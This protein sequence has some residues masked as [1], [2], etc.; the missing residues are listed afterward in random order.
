V[1]NPEVSIGVAAATAGLLGLIGLVSGYFPARTA[2]G[3]DPVV[4]MKT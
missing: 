3:L 1:G 4:A 2:A